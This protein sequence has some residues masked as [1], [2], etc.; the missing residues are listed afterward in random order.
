[1]LAL[2]PA[3]LLAAC[4]GSGDSASSSQDARA[5]QAASDRPVTDS[6]NVDAAIEE[7]PCELASAEMVA[8]LFEVPVAE[9]ERESSMSSACVY[10]WEN[11]GETERLDVKVKVSDVEEDRSE[12]HTSELQSLMR[13]S[14]AV[15]C[16]K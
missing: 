4:G 16:L 1:M 15:F 5:S 9:L 8:A 7:N 6:A 13:I 14:Y 2:V 3:L 10:S 11:A 12:E